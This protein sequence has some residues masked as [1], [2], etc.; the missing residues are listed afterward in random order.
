MKNLN[1]IAAVSAD[2]GIGKDNQLVWHLKPDMQFFRKITTGNIVVMGGNT[3]RSLNAQPLPKRENIVLTRGQIDNPAVQTFHDLASLEQ[4]L[5]Q[6]TQPIFVIGG[7]S[8]YREFLPEAEKIYLTEIQATR[9]ADTYF[10]DFDHT[11]Y[12]R[13]VLETG[14]EDGTEFEICEY[15][16]KD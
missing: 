12:D 14:E 10:P 5:A 2:G 4:Y 3:F 13:I 6:Q 7:A 15:T 16:R 9:P 1:L 8:L 11:K